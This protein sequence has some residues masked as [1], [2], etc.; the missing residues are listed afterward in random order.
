MAATSSFDI[1]SK[2]DRQ[3]VVNALDQARREIRTRFDLK[4]SKTEVELDGDRLTILTDG[5]YRLNT[6]RDLIES[7][8]VRRGVSLKTLR[9][10]EPEPA[11]GGN[12]RQTATLVQGIDQ[13]LGRQISKTIRTD[14]PKIQAQIQGDMIRVT[15]KSKDDL[16]AVIRTLRERDYPVELQFVNYR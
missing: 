13:D 5:E 1:V 8:L 7:K 2:Y 6:V 4:D 14:F 16:Q 9:Y 10:S 11:A 12:V 3:E 15:A